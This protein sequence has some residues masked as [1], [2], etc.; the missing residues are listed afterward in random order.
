MEIGT[1]SLKAGRPAL[2]GIVN[3]TPDSFSDGGFFADAASA[4]DHSLKLADEGAD[5][6]DVGGESTR[7]GA[8]AVSEEEESRR[9]IPVI[10]GIRRLSGIPVSIDTTKSL[11]ARRALDAG[12]DMINDISAG[13]FDPA[14]LDIA[15]QFEVP[16]CLMHMQG[17]PGSMQ[18]S[19]HYEDLV[20]EIV[21]FLSDAVERA[22]GAGVSRQRVIVDPGIGFGKSAED[23][24]T[25]LKRLREFRLSNCQEPCTQVQ[26]DIGF[27]EEEAI[28]ILIGTSRKSFLGKLL[29][30]DVNNR[31]E[32]TLASLA[33]AM[34]GGAS[35]LRVHDVGPVRRFV[36]TCLLLRR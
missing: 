30:F 5:I 4:I 2:M 10:E 9:V 19:P 36:D 23:N 16:I 12:A 17:S 29:G 24:V 11:V 33:L 25:I 8:E 14:I 1:F 21:A 35:I 20:G 15:A 13:R 26:G 7:P 18:I 31:L 27:D 32:G 34:E 28:P 22:A 3:A 6:I